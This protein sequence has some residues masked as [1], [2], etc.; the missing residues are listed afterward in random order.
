MRAGNGDV[1]G[2]RA[3]LA[4]HNLPMDLCVLASPLP[5]Y[6]SSNIRSDDYPS[7]V[8]YTAI[9]G[10]TP[11]EFDLDATGQ[12]INGRLLV[13]DPPYVF[14]DVTRRGI[15]TIRYDPPRRDGKP[16]ACRGM[17]QNV[18]WQLPY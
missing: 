14:D 18:R 15:T 13:S 11:T 8:V 1:A 2:A 4:G 12:A 16:Q 9:V 6:V 7:D 10:L 3:A 17:G 5:R